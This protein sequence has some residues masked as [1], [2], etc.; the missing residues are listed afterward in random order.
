ML[1]GQQE[2]VGVRVVSDAVEHVVRG[3]G[4]AVDREVR[5]VDHRCD[6]PVDRVDG[7]DPV[8]EPYVGPNGGAHALQFVQLIHRPAVQGDL[9][10]THWGEVVGPS[11]GDR[12]RTVGGGQRVVV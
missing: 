8:S 7:H 12:R 6:P 11:E 9:E 2:V 4:G 3:E 1:A 10:R 5:G